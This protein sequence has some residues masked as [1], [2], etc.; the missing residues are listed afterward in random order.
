MDAVSTGREFSFD[1]SIHCRLQYRD[2]HV[3]MQSV[4]ETDMS[5]RSR[6]QRL[7]CRYA[8]GYIDWHVDTQS[9]TETAPFNHCN[10]CFGYYVFGTIIDWFPAA[11]SAPSWGPGIEAE[12]SLLWDTPVPRCGRTARGIDYTVSHCIGDSGWL[13]FVSVAQSM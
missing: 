2:W 10:Y 3:D 6:L 1:M 12:M 11:I 5:I 9:V 13:Q 7:T 8:V 4:T